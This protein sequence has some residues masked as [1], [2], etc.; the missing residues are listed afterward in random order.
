MLSL[1]QLTKK[2]DKDYK[3]INKQ[4]ISSKKK[5]YNDVKAN[6]LF[7]DSC[8]ATPLILNNNILS[9]FTDKNKLK[10]LKRAVTS[11]DYTLTN[12]KNTQKNLKNKILKIK[13]YQVEY[14]N[15]I[16]L[17]LACLVLFLIGAPLGSIIRKGG[18]GVPLIT[19]VVI[20][21]IFHFMGVFFRGMADQGKIAPWLGAWLPTMIMFPFGI[22]LNF[23]AI[24]DKGIVDLSLFITPITN[25]IKKLKKD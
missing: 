7:K 9:D 18:F 11:I 5:Y 14:H 25:F 16:A 13:S 22:F 19:A 20:Y 3:P 15:R 21:V 17:A 12:I 1:N 10:I 4:I 2:I 23:R 6:K 24:N 8:V